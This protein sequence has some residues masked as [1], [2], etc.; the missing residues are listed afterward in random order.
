MTS[1]GP[2]HRAEGNPGL[3]HYGIHAVEAMYT[4]MGPGCEALSAIHKPEADVV[5]ARW[6]DGRLAHVRGLRAG[7]RSYGLLIHCAAGM[8]HVPISSRYAYRN[9]CREMVR[10]FETK[11]SPV[12]IEVTE[13]LICFCST[14]IES[15][16]RQGE[17]LE[18]SE[19]LKTD[20]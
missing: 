17:W 7:A 1:Y 5:T 10:F 3:L 8:F 16:R 13:E 2:A 11:T 9:L 18:L 14:A 15:E 6:K 19:S 20:G 4:L 12:P